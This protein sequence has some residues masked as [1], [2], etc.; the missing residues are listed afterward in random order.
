MADKASAPDHRAWEFAPDPFAARKEVEG[1]QE[2][3][4]VVEAQKAEAAAGGAS[5][6]GGGKGKGREG[7]GAGGWEKAP[8]VRMATGLREQVEATVRKVSVA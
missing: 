8:E 3:R 4:R 5:A 6:P 7:G 1:R 2:K